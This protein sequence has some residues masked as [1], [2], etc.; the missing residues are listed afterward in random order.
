MTTENRKV[1]LEIAADTSGVT[2]AFD[3]VK[4]AGRDMA[5]SVSQSGVEAEKGVSGIGDGAGVSE[6]K[7]DR[8]T[9]GIISSIQRA[10]AAAEAGERG[11]ARYFEAIASQRGV[12]A[13]AIKPYTAQLEAAV[14][15][16][17]QANRSLDNMG[18]S[19]KQTAAALRGVPA[20][21]TDIFTSLQGGQQPLTVLL[22]QG[23]QLKDMFGGAGSAAR[24]M[25]G[26]VAS[27]V[28]PVSVT[29]AALLTLGIAAY[30]GRQET[31]ALNQALLLSGNIAGTSAGNV[32]RMA[33]A[34][35]DLTGS[36]RGAS[37][38][39]LTQLVAGGNVAANQLEKAA[40]AALNLERYAG[41]A[42]AETIKGFN[43]LGRSPTAAVLKLNEQTRFLTADLYRQIKALEEQGR[44]AD[45]AA[46]AQQRYATAMGP[47]ADQLKHNMGTIERMWIGIKDAAKGAW[48]AMLNVGRE[49][50]LN[51]KMAANAARIKSLEDRLQT[52]R[53]WSPG[54]NR[55]RGLDT[56]GKALADE[57]Q[58]Q[59][60]LQEQ[61]RLTERAAESEA[62]RARQV[63]ATVEWQRIL[64]Q[65][66]TKQ[67]QRDREITR[68]TNLGRN[69]GASDAV[70]AQMVS[71]VREKYKEKPGGETND[72]E[73]AARAQIAR[74][75]AQEKLDAQIAG[76]FSKGDVAGQIDAI[77]RVA[78]V[79]IDASE[80]KAVAL[81]EL[82]SAQKDA[83][84]VA[85]TLGERDQALIAGMGAVTS[86]RLEQS[87]IIESVTQSMR[88]QA[89]STQDQIAQYTLSGEAL[90][91]YQ[92]AR[93]AATAAEKEALATRLEMR[94]LDADEA[95]NVD[96]ADKLFAAAAASREYAKAV[97]ELAKTKEDLAKQQ[98]IDAAFD[99]AARAAGRLNKGLGDLVAGIGKLHKA[100]DTMSKDAAKG[101]RE[102]IGAYGDLAG[103]AKTFF[104][105][106]TTAYQ[107]LE[108]AEKGFRVLELAL[109][110]ENLAK[111]LGFISAET[112]VFV[113]AE[114]TKA[115]A[116]GKTSVAM[117]AQAPPPA[118]QISAVGMLAFLAGVGIAVSGSG[119]GGGGGDPLAY[120][121]GVQAKQG[122]GTVLGDSEAKSES[123]A[124]SLGRLL[125]L[126][127]QQLR[128]SAGMLDSLRS[129]DAAMSGL[130]RA[131]FK[132]VGL[133]AGTGM[134]VGWLGKDDHKDSDVIKWFSF[135]PFVRNIFAGALDGLFGKTERRVKDSGLQFGGTTVADY[136]AMQAAINQYQT[137]ET[138]SSSW[139][140]SSTSRATY[141]QGAGADFDRAVR[142]MYSGL[143]DSLSAAAGVFG[144][145]AAA[146]YGRVLQSSAGI[147]TLSL[148]GLKGED[149]TDA[150]NNYFSTAFDK[151]AQGAMPMLDAFQR[152]GEGY[153]ETVI[154]VAN[155]YETAQASLG[156]LGAAMI[157]LDKVARPLAEDIGAELA[158]ESL[159]ASEAVRSMSTGI[160]DLVSTA[161]GGAEDIA[162]LYGALDTLR[163][164]L[165]ALGLDGN[166]VGRDMVSGAGGTE[167]LFSGV[168]TYEAEFLSATQQFTAEFSRVGSEF[169][170]LGLVMPSTMDGF[171]GLVESLDL[172]TTAG[173]KTFGQLM[174]LSGAF[175]DLQKKLQ[176]TASNL[177]A[178][179][180]EQTISAQISALRAEFEAER[181]RFVDPGYTAP[182]YV[183]SGTMEQYDAD[184]K[185]FFAMTAVGFNELAVTYGSGRTDWTAESLMQMYKDFGYMDFA[186]ERAKYQTTLDAEY[187]DWLAAVAD[188]R[189]AYDNT[190][191]SGQAQMQTDATAFEQS[192][193]TLISAN[194]A[195][196]K[197]AQ[198]SAATLFMSDTEA[199]QYQ[200]GQMNAAFA[201]L[202]LPKPDSLAAY[203]DA[204]LGQ[205][206]S[207]LSGQ[208]QFEALIKWADVFGRAMQAA[209]DAAEQAAQEQA[210]A[211]AEAAR[212]AEVAAAEAAR[213]AEALA[214]R[215]A[216][217]E[218]ALLEAQG[219]AAGAKAARRAMELA[220]LDESL[221]G[222]QQQIYDA[223][224]LSE[225][226]RLAKAAADE[227]LRA[228]EVIRAGWQR[229]ADSIAGTMETLRK[230]LLGEDAQSFAR[231][232]ADF[233]IANAAARA[234]DQSAADKLPA[235]ARALVDMGKTNAGSAAEQTLLTARTLA[236]LDVTLK[237]LADS[238]GITVP[239]YAAGGAF[240]GGLRLVGEN[241][242]ELEVTGPSR[243]YSAQQTADMLA[244]GGRMSALLAEL[245]AM[246][247]DNEALRAEVRAVATHTHKSA[248]KLEEMV[249]DGVIV[250]TESGAPLQTVT[251]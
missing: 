196:L 86:A 3:D 221:R 10:T 87:K 149:L 160:A 169:E 164:T 2:R 57:R 191:A 29:A 37:I 134:D 243:I 72:F 239:A 93:S 82:A 129:I 97:R 76:Q 125:E 244:G 227:Q 182:A 205:D 98:G 154:R 180:G 75:T 179:R 183:P 198:S 195:A 233:A 163:T 6:Q 51:D 208:D 14:K 238:Y 100:N 25:G 73:Q 232:Q 58:E 105:E 102:Q 124:K 137:V 106:R 231:A 28:T 47:V 152:G 204:V 59:S 224:D 117:A 212:L 139:F 241:G 111:K 148:M 218:A 138:K 104:K 9:R 177:Q 5:K 32:T 234:G 95:G 171:R 230:E 222:L 156:R 20:Q 45:A 192:I 236:A 17:E 121:K 126:D 74:I 50:T 21:F 186:A 146:A 49:D 89:L 200:I 90:L 62:K 68:V 136:I 188:S 162:A 66:A 7:I 159:L 226:A 184:L 94:A 151:I 158:R 127:A 178:S 92:L 41:I 216:S 110:A 114:T 161:Q 4:A 36:T 69:A 24:A 23:G 44:T 55:D 54:T 223:L 211:A 77:E 61:A 249:G 168:A 202:N 215:R 187:T 130:S 35:A 240:G 78:R 63:Q 81:Y 33:R 190:V 116:A 155:G 207:S 113:A 141:T 65:L 172:G 165:Q 120:A 167:A 248:R 250:R 246:R 135:A 251:V 123:I 144:Q 22:Q 60:L 185:A 219:D 143:A 103:A 70:I 99:E 46:L 30:K 220:S 210:R 84:D 101:T 96:Q 228:Q 189:A 122:A 27:L 199:L 157:S 71:R 145:D 132:S 133:T 170:R 31:E 52:I 48:D 214:S 209:T 140:G 225:T 247:R 131:V 194:A 128:Y 217:M 15:K 39:V 40:A 19:A 88:D 42:V 235:L 166:G 11:T 8:A 175:S 173:Q 203:R 147:G 26:Y 109:A 64:D 229:T 91:Q 118:G 1:Q 79:H 18:L 80:R 38:D 142:D 85:K 176:D 193:A 181:Y 108:A 242:P 34:V 245:Q 197:P 115:T 201:A 150:V 43:E 16:Q 67:E 53:G 119:G 174:S 112:S 56:V 107:A 13:D 237:T 12:S 206:L 213:L 83:G 153:Y